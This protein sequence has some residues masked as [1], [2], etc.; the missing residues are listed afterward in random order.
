MSGEARI[1]GCSVTGPKHEEKDRPCEDAWNGERFSDGQ[2]VLAVADGLG[3][4]PEAAMG[5]EIATRE[6]TDA[7]TEYLESNREFTEKT[8]ERAFK[9]AFVRTREKLGVEAKKRELSPRDLGTTLLAVVGGPA[10]IA[11]AVVGDGGIVYENRESYS[12]LVPREEKILDIDESHI[13]HVIQQ[14]IWERSYRFGF[15]EEYDGVAVFSDG[16]QNF[17]WDDLETAKEQFFEKVFELV[18]K[19]EDPDIARE[20]MVSAFTEPPY[21]TTSSDDKTIAIGITPPETETDPTDRLPEGVLAARELFRDLRKTE[22]VKRPGE[23]LGT[24]VETRTG[25]QFTLGDV[26]ATAE[27]S[28]TFRVKGTSEEFVKVYEPG[29]R[30]DADLRSKIRALT[31]TY[32]NFLSNATRCAKCAWPTDLVVAADGDQFLG[33]KMTLSG[34]ESPDNILEAGSERAKTSSGS[35]IE[36]TTSFLQQAGVVSASDERFAV[37][38]QLA[39]IVGEIHDAGHAIGN[40]DHETVF[41]ENGCVIL[42]N[43]DTYCI[44]GEVE[45]HAAEISGPRYTPPEGLYGPVDAVRKGDRFS[46]AVH[47]FQHLLSGV[48]PYEAEGEETVR[49][50]YSKMIRENP[51]PYRDPVDGKYEPPV[52]VDRYVSLPAEIRRHFERCFIEGRENPDIRPSASEWVEVLDGL[53]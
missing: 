47:I 41:V 51:F 46:L 30:F 15:R 25:E 36:T 14:D 38:R 43:C 50:D 3:E 17:A 18:R 7:L 39:E 1:V 12:L 6:V 34:L 52:D 37:P 2:F 4:A 31:D 27:E 35:L 33:Y 49:G 23:F 11:G 8:A 5:S 22:A 10:G 16:F 42:T 13:T 19:I 9:E 32:P 26:V 20:E 28:S 29:R 44:S 45:T 21:T 40:L 53:T 48:H 24:D